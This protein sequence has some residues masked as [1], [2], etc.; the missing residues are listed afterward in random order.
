MMWDKDES[1][2]CIFTATQFHFS[3]DLPTT[4]GFCLPQRLVVGELGDLLRSLYLPKMAHH[5][6][7]GGAVAVVDSGMTASEHVINGNVNGHFKVAPK[8]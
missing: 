7:D 5:S 1:G 6:L 4:V 2:S 3:R 8:E